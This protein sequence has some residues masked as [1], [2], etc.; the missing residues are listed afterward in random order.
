M[1]I[2]NNLL[3]NAIKHHDLRKQQPFVRVKA[4]NDSG[5]GTF[6]VEVSD[7]GTGIEESCLDKVFDRFFRATSQAE[8]SGLGLHIVQ[9]AVEKL[10]G[11]VR[12]WSR[13]WEGSVFT[14]T[15]P[16]TGA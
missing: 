8:G 6:T 9:Q 12:L 4:W 5:R 14:V 10:G 3:T 13:Y 16:S 11:N 15:L 7:N 1:V 2:L